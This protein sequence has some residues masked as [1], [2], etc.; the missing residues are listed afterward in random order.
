MKMQLF[1]YPNRPTLI[2]PDP[3]NPLDP[4][5]DYINSLE[6]SGL[7]VGENKWNGDNIYI[8]TDTMEI[9]NRHHEQHHYSPPPEVMDELQKLPKGAVIN[10][11]LMNF[12]TTQVKNLI[13]VHSI[14]VWNGKPLLG[15][16]WGDARKI[17]EDLSYG[18]HVQLSEI[19]KSGFW[20]RYQKADGTIIEG[21]ILK[22]PVGKLVFSTTPINDVPW[23]KK[24]RKPCK[25][26]SF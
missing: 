26:Y 22:N 1:Y 13:I 2:P 11:E 8:Y 14:M 24:I 23:M 25:K 17:I 19:F 4:K 10:A 20:E 21:I 7:Y 15:K 5:P 9:W 16:T 3:L 12:R 18:K 6:A